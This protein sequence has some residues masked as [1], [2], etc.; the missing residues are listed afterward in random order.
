[1]KCVWNLVDM[2]AIMRWLKKLYLPK[3]IC[4][5]TLLGI[6]NLS[7]LKGAAIQELNIAGNP[8]AELDDFRDHVM[9]HLPQLKHLDGTDVV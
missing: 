6:S 3:K 5:L 8:V 7:I 4:S 2:V 1:M 9:Q